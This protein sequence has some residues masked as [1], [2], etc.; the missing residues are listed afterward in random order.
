MFWMPRLRMPTYRPM[1]AVVGCA[2]LLVLGLLVAA[3]P[4]HEKLH[5]KEAAAGHH[6]AVCAFAKG[7][8]D[9]ASAS[10]V[11][12]AVT[13]LPVFTIH[14]PTNLLPEPVFFLLPP[15]RAPPCFSVVS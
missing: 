2:L 6:C 7:Q 11:L 12:A 9:V 1:L 5:H 3:A 14:L 13:L 4:L 15:G 8:V 10:P